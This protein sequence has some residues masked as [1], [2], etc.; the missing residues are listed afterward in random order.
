MLHVYAKP[1][2]IDPEM[3]TYA[4]FIFHV[5]LLLNMLNIYIHFGPPILYK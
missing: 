3:C 4:I 1:V 5:I 2:I